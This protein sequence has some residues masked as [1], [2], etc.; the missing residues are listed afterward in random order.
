VEGEK[1]NDAEKRDDFENWVWLHV[2]IRLHEFEVEI[3][4]LLQRKILKGYNLI[5]AFNVL[6]YIGTQKSIEFVNRFLDS[7]N[8]FLRNKAFACIKYI[9]ERNIILW[10]NNEEK[11]KL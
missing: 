6:F 7:D 11:F 9:Y 2:F 10:Y 5:A 4:K 8:E 3:I 1:N